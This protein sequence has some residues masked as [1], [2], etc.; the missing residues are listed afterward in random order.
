MVFFQDDSIHIDLRSLNKIDFYPPHDMVRFGA[1]LTWKQVLKV[2]DPKK[3]T[4]IHG[5]AKNVG[6]GGYLSGVGANPLGTTHRHGYGADNVLR[7]KMVLADGSVA[8][9]TKDNTTIIERY[10]NR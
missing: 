1:G 8:L 10:G 2:V 4:I 3:Y 9:I 7:Y 5:N 6:V